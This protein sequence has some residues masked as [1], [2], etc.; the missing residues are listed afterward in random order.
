MII[1]NG[2]K[3]AENE[4]EFIN[5]L[6]E[7]KTTAMGYAKRNKRSV[8]LLNI[9]KEK[10]GV[11]N[12]HGVIGSATKQDNGRYWYSYGMPKGIEEYESYIEQVEEPISYAIGRDEKGYIFK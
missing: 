7:G 11:I 8:S 10:I 9:Q 5:T 2:T 3:W 12:C 4:Q 1:L 6:F